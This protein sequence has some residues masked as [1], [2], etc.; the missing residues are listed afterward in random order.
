MAAGVTF[1]VPPSFV[2][3][4][5]MLPTLRQVLRTYGKYVGP[6][7]IVSV[8][9]SDP[10]NW[11]TDL[12]GGSAFG[13][14]LIC[15]IFVSNLMAIMLQTLSLRLG[16]ATNTDLAQSC[17][18]HFPRPVCIFL[19]IGAEIAIMACDLAEIIGTAIAINLLTGLAIQ[20]GVLITSLDVLMLMVLWDPKRRHIFE[21]L[22]MLLVAVVFT[23]MCAIVSFSNPDWGAVGMGFVP[24]KVLLTQDGLYI[25]IGIL[26]A[27]VMP[28]N[29]YLHSHLVK[30]H[31][32][33]YN[34]GASSEFRKTTDEN[35]DTEDQLLWLST[36]TSSK[37]S[38]LRQA[39]RYSSIDTAI[40]LCLAFFINCS[41]LIVAAANFNARNLTEVADIKDAYT[42]LIQF[43]GPAAATMFAVALLFSGQSSTVTG[44]LAG[45]VVMEG[46]LGSSFSVS[47]WVRR[48]VTRV[49]AIVPAMS[50]A[51]FMGER[52]VN[53]LLV[54]SQVVLSF[55]LPFAVFPLIYFTTSK[56]IMDKKFVDGEDNGEDVVVYG[57]ANPI[58]VVA[59]AVAA[60][61]LI[62]GL[63]CF[64]IFKFIMGRTG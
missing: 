54:L 30:L 55:Q 9:Y 39:I 4:C 26:G 3:L 2:H 41:I 45:Q 60:G 34:E 53:D 29:I 19:Y 36:N 63:N 46:F 64:L 56:K 21:F 38:E 37:I 14:S 47:P 49:L 13:Y 33:Q 51:I 16:F 50:V 5:Q 43:L 11:S 12:A 7:M 18:K 61:L 24:S 59:L 25:A 35:L 23:C 10:G 22:I 8:G 27:T 62:T 20:W 31:A 52:G 44:T 32:P 6:G 40:S 57:F 17:R 15:V 42:L 1:Q 58:W 48:I 28:H